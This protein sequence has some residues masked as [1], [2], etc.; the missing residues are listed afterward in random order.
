MR[1][2]SVRKPKFGLRIPSFPVDGSS[3]NVFLDQI[4]KFVEHNK[5][6]FDSAWVSDHFVPWANFLSYTTPI[7]EGFSTTSF[8]I[9]RFKELIFGNIV[10]CNSYRNPALLA[11]MGATLQTLSNG[12]FVLGMGSGW[13][14][15]EY[16]AYGYEFLP[17]K[18]RIQ[19]LEEGIQIIRKMWTEDVSTFKGKYYKIEKAYCYPRPVPVPPIMVGGG[20]E[21]L[22]LKV[23]ARYADWWNIPNVSPQTYEHKLEVLCEH[24]NKEGRD[25]SKIVRTLA[26]MVSI[27]ESKDEALNI[28]IKSSFVERGKEDKFIIG[29]PD[30]V[31]ERIAEYI[32]LGVE[33]FILRFLDFPLMK[34]ARQFAREVIP[35][36]R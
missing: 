33:H 30:L 2:R 1:L 10:L 36:F 13:K 17:A 29:D 27:S 12:R 7:L 34:G 18:I 25:P 20:G 6:R 16:D 32:D 4:L 5:T 35:K 26:T 21:K 19:Q 23:V 14:R 9:G 24:C 28:A 8:L 22:T 15:D 3:E 11:K 31:A